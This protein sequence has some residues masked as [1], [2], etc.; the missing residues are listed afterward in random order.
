MSFKV[1]IIPEDPTNNGYI[2]QPLVQRLMSQCGRPNSKVEVLTNPRAGGYEHAKS[3]IVDEVL[4]RYSHFDL[5]LFMPD[6]DGKDRSAEFQ[7]LE[8]VA[9]DRGVRLFCCAAVEEV[10]AWLLAGHLDKLGQAWPQI[11]QN[12]S[13]K[14]EVFGPFL[15]AKGDARRAGG[16]RDLL[17]KET[18]ANYAG[19]IERC[20]EIREL[21]TRISDSLVAP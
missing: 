20:P 16:G 1:K 15:R 9:S 11:R 4:D 7:H 2:L 18:L 5:L 6:A 17:M 13:V 12:T 8:S 19:L 14:E 3:L 21:Q 10:E